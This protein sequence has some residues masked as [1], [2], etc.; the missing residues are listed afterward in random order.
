MFVHPY[1][2]I[3]DNSSEESTRR[4]TR[5]HADSSSVTVEGGRVRRERIESS[6]AGPDS[7]SSSMLI[8]NYSSGGTA[9]SKA[10]QN[11]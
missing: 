3:N 2:G 1:G 10:P 5:R 6:N 9:T 11:I 7:P 4:H 8:P